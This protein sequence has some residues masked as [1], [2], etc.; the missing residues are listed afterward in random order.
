MAPKGKRVAA[1]PSAIKKD[2]A[3]A[4][5]VNP[6]F[7]KREKRFGIGG[8]PA[9]KHDLHRFVKW[10]K[11]VR[12]QRQRRVLNQRLK[13][14]P[15]LHRFTK[16]ADKNLAETIFK[17]LLKYRPE[18]KAAKKQRLLSEAEAR[19][20]GTKTDK[21]KPV[22]VK[23][24]LNHV[25]HLVET[26]KA[27]L[28]VIAHDVDPIELVVWLPAVCRKMD[29]PYIIVKGKARLGTVV[30]M[31]NAA[32]LALT[33]VKGEDQ[34]ELDKVLESARTGFNDAPRMSWGGGIMGPKSQAK[35]RKRDR[36]LQ[37]DLAQ[38]LG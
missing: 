1:A 5:P 31:K 26:G 23:Y 38:R 17:L 24:G 35:A 34:R 2:K 30:H 13:V 11:Y 28:V 3:P 14:P 6:L 25:T 21:K 18:D 22:V 19:E 7:E 8:T 15:A 32:A 9:P 33:A 12:I 16:A 10:P 37:K 36:E 27:K 20:K 29:V 4:K